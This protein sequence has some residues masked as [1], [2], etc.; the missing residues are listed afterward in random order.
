MKLFAIY[1]TNNMARYG[2]AK[3]LNLATGRI[4]IMTVINSA[5]MS[6]RNFYLVD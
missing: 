2:G 6:F 5:V 3:A 1:I 4:N